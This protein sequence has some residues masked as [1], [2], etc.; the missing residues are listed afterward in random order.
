MYINLKKKNKLLIQ[1]LSEVYKLKIKT[2]HVD[3]VDDGKLNK[4][5][6]LCEFNSFIK[7]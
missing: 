6:D 4:F 5:R 2:H 3:K 7:N 1:I